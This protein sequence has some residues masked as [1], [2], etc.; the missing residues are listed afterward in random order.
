MTERRRFT[1]RERVALYLAAGGR[2]ERCGR[3]LEPGWHADHVHPYSKSGPTDVTNGAALCPHCNAQKGDTIMR[4]LRDWQQAALTTALTSTTCLI[5]ATPA[6]GKTRL[7]LEVVRARLGR[8]VS[9]IVWVVP[10]DAL[11]SQTADS[12]HDNYGIDLTADFHNAD[13]RWS[14]DYNGAVVTYAQVAREPALWR[15]LVSEVGTQVVLDEVH[16]CSDE[17]SWGPA[18]EEAFA[19][20]RFRLLMSGTP[21]RHDGRPI[22]WVDYDEDGRAQPDYQ[23]GYRRA[24][25]D[26]VVRPVRFDILDAQVRWVDV[27]DLHDL[28]LEDVSLDHEGRALRTAIDPSN[29]WVEAALTRADKELSNAR[30]E[31]PSLGAMC[32]AANI[33]A[34]ERVAGILTRITGEAPVVVHERIDNAPAAIRR[35]ADG[36]QR[37]LV[38]VN[39]VSEGVDIPR[40]GIG[41]YATNIRTDL[42]FWQ[43]VGRTTRILD[44]DDAH[45]AMWV[46][47]SAPGVQALA[48]RFA[49]EADAGLA[50]AEEDV[51]RE[52]REERERAEG[53]FVPLGADDVRH[54]GSLLHGDAIPAA[55]MAQIE[56]LKAALGLRDD[57]ALLA[58]LI[59]KLGIPTAAPTTGPASGP[60]K[61]ARKRLVRTRI[62]KLVGRMAF[63]FDREPKHINAALIRTTGAKRNDA[64]E[65][66][67]A[68]Q[69]SL[70]VE[71]LLCDHID[72]VPWLW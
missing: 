16:H 26:H 6:S 43:M 33:D 10:S 38:A 41:V 64:T 62:A 47:P 70:L 68:Q 66:Q 35:F 28:R 12:A 29:G 55:L 65:D 56:E 44:A 23:Y 32:V 36:A 8:D 18:I 22:P 48:Q 25:K 49:H 20:T 7:G 2:C 13:G 40:L 42:R 17:G 72:E 45:I 67:L 1:S 15:R 31:V 24:V 69:E 39:M 21:F 63:Q 60:S 27:L 30:D 46:I 57:T 19:P 61:D 71:A 3:Q 53:L 59:E 4:P 52:E 14:S 11:R 5:E 9:R 50:E 51:E 37:W 54:I 34:A 58:Q